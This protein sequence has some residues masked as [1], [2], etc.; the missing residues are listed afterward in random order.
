MQLYRLQH[1]SLLFDSSLSTFIT[2]SKIHY[3]YRPLSGISLFELEDRW[4]ITS[5]TLMGFRPLPG[6]SLFEFRSR[7]NVQR[8]FCILKFPSPTGDFW[9]VTIKVEPILAEK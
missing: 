8:I 5:L 9:S 7:K 6:I 2:T 3:Y 4:W 1:A